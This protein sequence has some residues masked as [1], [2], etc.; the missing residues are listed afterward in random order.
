ME[1]LAGKWMELEITL[2]LAASTEASI[3]RSF[4][5]RVIYREESMKLNQ[6]RKVR[7]RGE[8]KK[9]HGRGPTPTCEAQGA[10]VEDTTPTA[11]WE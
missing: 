5:M 7:G 2:R 9:S 11:T 4:L 10:G 3:P 1:S 8:I 6:R